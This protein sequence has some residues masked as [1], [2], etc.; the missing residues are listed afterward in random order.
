M[1]GHVTFEVGIHNATFQCQ[2]SRFSKQVYVLDACQS[3]PRHALNAFE[4]ELACLECTGL[5]NLPPLSR[6]GRAV[7]TVPCP[8]FVQL[9]LR[10]SGLPLSL[11]FPLKQHP[12]NC[13]HIIS[14]Q[15]G[16]RIA[17]VPTES[18]SQRCYEY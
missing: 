11:L 15:M 10:Y 6:N 12:A 2:I 9:L 8:L 7:V 4:L 3:N 14:R 18:K 5:Q 16:C 1:I 13:W 17:P